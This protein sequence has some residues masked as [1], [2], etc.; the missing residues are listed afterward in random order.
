[1]VSPTIPLYHVH[2]F[3]VSV[4]AP[5]D[6]PFRV[7]VSATFLHESGEALSNLP[8]FYDGD[9][10]WRIRFSPTRPGVWTGITSSTHAD[11]HAVRLGPVNAVAN[12]NPRVHGRVRVDTASPRRFRFEDGAPF[13]YLA[14]E[15]DW[16]FA[17]H[18]TRPN[19]CRRLV[20]TIVE[21]GFNTVVTT[22]YS[23]S[24]FSD[25]SSEWV[26]DP[27]ALY[28]F[29]G[30]NDSPDHSRLNIPFFRDFDAV[31]DYLH[32][33]GVVLHLMLQVQNKK[34]RWPA[35]RSAEDDMYWRYIVARYQAYPNV[36]WDVS[37]ESFNLHRETGSHDYTLDRMR[38]VRHAD[39]YRHL[40]TVHDPVGNSPAQTSAVDDACDFISDQIHLG[41]VGL[42]NRE[43][44]RRFR[45]LPK[46][47]VNVEYGYE[48]GAEDIKTYRSPT[49]RP[50]QD[51]LLWTYAIYVGG[52]H[53][54]YYYNNTSWDLVK[55]EPEPPGWA[56]YRYLVDL[57]AE[58]DIRRMEPDNDFVQGGYC[59]AERGRQYLVLLP[60]GGNC[61][62]DLTAVSP[63]C[64]LEARWMDIY[65]G[66]R[67]AT[68]LDAR[69]FAV[70]LSNPLDAPAHPCV[71]HVR[72]RE[73]G[74][75]R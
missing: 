63:T 39:A 6:N 9:G 20:D 44:V 48:L 26:F 41:D 53:A 23:H 72:T 74:G 2:D 4:R 62:I 40:V 19:A 33:K 56:R 59:L 43:A 10:T 45:T 51:I 7:S 24:G 28:P 13:V 46:P 65:T 66:A 67:S 49:T 75:G 25:P 50:W 16:L 60:H 36:V 8:G 58:M 37:K 54:C 73:E 34:V 15:C 1:M 11:L 68:S 12:G 64:P 71:V 30:T 14:F 18:Q 31:V 42:Y 5:F 27:P 52:G 55:P 69:G 3:E 32:E 70:E 21:R 61:A 29:G 57:L 47:Y 22:M 38:I 35:R 17:L